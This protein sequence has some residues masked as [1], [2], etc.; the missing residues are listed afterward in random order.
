MYL[1]EFPESCSVSR[2]PPLEGN[3][4]PDDTGTYTWIVAHNGKVYGVYRFAPD[5]WYAGFSGTYP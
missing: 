4:K 3:G 2:G 5:R 1:T